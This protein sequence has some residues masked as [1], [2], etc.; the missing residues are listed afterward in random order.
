MSDLKSEIDTLK[1]AL[2]A[3]ASEFPPNADGDPDTG[4][5]HQNIR[6]LKLDADRYQWLRQLDNA[7]DYVSLQRK[8]AKAHTPSQLDAAI[9][10]AMK[11]EKP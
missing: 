3:Y 2:I 4:N 1:A 10:K 9:D 5:I 7:F 6:Q 8:W 11:G